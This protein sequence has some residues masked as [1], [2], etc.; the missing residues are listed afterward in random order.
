M[1]GSAD[2][3]GRV[4]AARRCAAWHDARRSGSGEAIRADLAMSRRDAQLTGRP[5]R[6]AP[7]RAARSLPPWQRTRALASMP[8]SFK[9]MFT[10][11]Y[12]LWRRYLLRRLLWEGNWKTFLVR[13]LCIFKGLLGMW[14]SRANINLVNTGVRWRPV[15]KV[16][17]C[18]NNCGTG[19][20]SGGMRFD[21]TL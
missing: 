18:K 16:G 6:A 19:R 10:I 2:H 7:P 15:R 1:A 4:A 14:V 11:S 8:V 20:L 17:L 5:T 13:I 12:Y 21:G 9:L 3:G